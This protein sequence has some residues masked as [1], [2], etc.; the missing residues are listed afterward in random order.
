MARRLEV[1]IRTLRRYIE[2]LQDLGIPV[3]AERGRYGA[4]VLGPGYKLPP[5]MF[6]DDEALAL[7]LGLHCR[8]RAGLADAAPAV[9]SALRKTGAGD[10]RRRADAAVAHRAQSRSTCAK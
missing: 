4:Y 9:E 7:T 6:T 5:M 2:M 8:A 3:V 10:A 1:D